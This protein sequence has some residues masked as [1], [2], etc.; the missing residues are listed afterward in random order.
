MVPVKRRSRSS[1]SF[2][3]LF[4]GNNFYAKGGYESLLAFEQLAS[5]YDCHFTAIGDI[6]PEAYVRFGKNSKAAYSRRALYHLEVP[7]S[8]R[9]APVG[10]FLPSIGR[11]GPDFLE[12]WDEILQP[13]QQ[14]TGALR[15]VHI[16]RRD[17]DHSRQSQRI[18]QKMPLPPFHT[19][20][21]V[22]PA[23]ASRFLHR[24]DRLRVHDGRAGVR[25][26]ADPPA[27]SI[28]HCPVQRCP[29]PGP[30]QLLTMIVHGLPWRE[31][32]RQVALGAAC[33][34]QVNVGSED[35]A[36]GVAAESARR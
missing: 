25:V 6:P 26:F 11:I 19:C 30:A 29:E 7:I 24:L 31:N 4:I 10:Q 18:D 23:D 5:D 14:P 36:E 8:L 2:N 20:M 27:F 21:S 33:A 35:R 9:F 13:G 28:A 22:V 34:Q 16:R 12:P 15:V 3:F 32:A 1:R 17:R